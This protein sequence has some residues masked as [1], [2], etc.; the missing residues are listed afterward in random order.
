MTAQE[1][2]LGPAPQTAKYVLRDLDRIEYE[3]ETV[4]DIDEAARLVRRAKKRMNS[5]HRRIQEMA[6][7]YA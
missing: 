1:G 7:T 5:L 4:K 6:A 2:K 3:L